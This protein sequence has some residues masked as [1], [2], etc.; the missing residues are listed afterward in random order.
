MRLLG[1]PNKLADKRSE[2][3][4]CST[5]R[6]KC[7]LD[8]RFSPAIRVPRSNCFSSFPRPLGAVSHNNRGVFVP[9]VLQEET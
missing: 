2:H 1:R 7:G 4:V 9:S 8:R 5:G 3:F 6:G